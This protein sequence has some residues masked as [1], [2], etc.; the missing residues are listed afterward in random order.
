PYNAPPPAG[1]MLGALLLAAAVTLVP[2]SSNMWTDGT[3]TWMG[4]QWCAESGLLLLPSS[5]AIDAGIFIPDFHCPVAGPDPSGCVEWWGAAPDSGACEYIGGT[6]P[7][8]QNDFPVV[9]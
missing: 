3:Y 4:S 5:P 6:T 7:P 9:L 1:N 2:G 8:P